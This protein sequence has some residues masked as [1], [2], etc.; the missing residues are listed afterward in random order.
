MSNVYQAPDANLDPSI[1]TDGFG[2]VEKA[3]AG[4][5]TLEIG[6]VLSEAWA[7]TKGSK[8][9]IWLAFL[10]ILLIMIPASIVPPLVAAVFDGSGAMSLLVTL[11]VQLAIN[12]LMLPIMAGMW[13]IGIKRAVGVPVGASEIF[14]YFGKTGALFLCMLL[15]Y[16]LV[17][18]GFL[19]LILP[20]IYLLVAFGMAM[21]LI[22]EKNMGVWEALQ[23]SRKA[24]THQWFT[25][26]GL[27]LVLMVIYLLGALFTLGIGLIWIIPLLFLVA[28][29]VYR[30]VFGYSQKLA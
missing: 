15:M 25:F 3:L 28:G 24:M 12:L 5:Y 10:L 13:M 6:A 20:G 2:S 14:A 4:N 11:V 29:V 9:T 19:L 23:T 27:G 22:V 8:G 1:S 16:L 21:P 17:L 30:T 7:K 18:V 26:F